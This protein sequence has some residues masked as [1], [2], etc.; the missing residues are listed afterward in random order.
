M[1]KGC[2]S[3]VLFDALKSEPARHPE[4]RSLVQNEALPKVS[5]AHIRIEDH[6]KIA[7]L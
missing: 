5:W 1:V 3:N 2:A 6:L 4:D 7:S